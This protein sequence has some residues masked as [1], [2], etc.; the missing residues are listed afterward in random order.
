MHT[1]S[2]FNGIQTPPTH[3]SAPAGPPPASSALSL[4]GCTPAGP[5]PN[6]TRSSSGLL[7]I[8]HAPNL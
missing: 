6:T 4:A 7:R 1:G 8:Q 5:P 3:T 2:T